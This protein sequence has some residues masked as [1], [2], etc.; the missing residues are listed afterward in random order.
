MYEI[1]WLAPDV[2]FEDRL[3]YTGMTS[4]VELCPLNEG[5]PSQH[6]SRRR[7]DRPLKVIGPVRPLTDFE[8][9][10][11]GDLV[12][13]KNIV[14]LFQASGF[15]G[16]DFQ[17]VEIFT[18]T[19]TPIGREAFEIRVKGWGGFAPKESGIRVLEECPVCKRRVFSGYTE[20]DNLFHFES[21][22]GSDFFIIWPLPRYIFVTGRVRDAI[23]KSHYTG[24]RLC[25]LAELPTPISGKLGPG[26]LLDWFDETKVAEI[27]SQQ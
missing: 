19:Q 12:V 4:H 24:V 20:R 1:F 17:P 15:T 23:L 13:S 16:A 7:W 9:T 6:A 3:V 10:V 18:T 26:N 5:L 22:D 14:S 27:M 25:R 8:W 2:K 21:W 11:Y